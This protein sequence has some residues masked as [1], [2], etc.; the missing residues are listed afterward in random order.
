[1][2]KSFDGDKRKLRVKSRRRFVAFYWSI[3]PANDST[4]QRRN[5]GKPYGQ[6]RTRIHGL[7]ADRMD[8]TEY[9]GKQCCVALDDS[10]RKMLAGVECDNATAEQSIKGL[11]QK[12]LGECE[13]MRR[14]REIITDPGT[15]FWAADFKSL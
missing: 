13:R 12:V 1:M 14:I 8:W 15:Q 7:S 11:A 3:K 2:A 6:L 10:N 4:L 5:R 9:D